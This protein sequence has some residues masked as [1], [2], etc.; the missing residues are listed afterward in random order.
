MS[1][2][3]KPVIAVTDRDEDTVWLQ[4]YLDAVKRYGG[5]PRLIRP[6]GRTS[7]TGRLDGVTGLMLSGGEDIDPAEYGEEVDPEAGVKS[8]PERDRMEMEVLREALEQDMPVLAICR[9]MQVLNVFMGGK[10]IQ[11]LDG[12]RGPDLETDPTAYHRIYITPGSKLAAVVGSGGMVRINS[13]HH[14]G[15]REAQKAPGLLASAYALDDGLIEGME[16]PNHRWVIGV[17]FHPE[18]RHEVPPHFDRLFEALVDRAAEHSLAT[19][20]TTV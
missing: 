14:Q 17:Q 6:G 19:A 16:S 4:P 7:H 10:L 13:I 15:A 8:S 12:H 18:R 11:H 3:P 20:R 2:Q 9:G 1:K 5:E